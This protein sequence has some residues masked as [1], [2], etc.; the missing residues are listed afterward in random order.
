MARGPIP[1]K[2]RTR[3]SVKD[4]VPLVREIYQSSLT[5]C[6]LHIALDDGNIEDGHLEFCGEYARK[7]QHQV[8]AQVAEGMRAM[9]RT[10][11]NKLMRVWRHSRQRERWPSRIGR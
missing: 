7:K 2:P 6:C 10:Q 4:L 8:C 5:G 1:D 9:T 3:P 11:R